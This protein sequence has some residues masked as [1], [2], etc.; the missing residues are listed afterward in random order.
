MVNN[1][2]DE[3][4]RP[5]ERVI[6][7][8]A[9]LRAALAAKLLENWDAGDHAANDELIRQLGEWHRTRRSR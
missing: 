1:M 7:G 8:E 3:P 6:T 5:G 9:D 2:S 4:A